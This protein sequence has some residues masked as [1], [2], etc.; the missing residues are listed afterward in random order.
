MGKRSYE[1]QSLELTMW[2][3][4][5]YGG[6]SFELTMLGQMSYGGQ[7]SELTMWGQSKVGNLHFCSF[8]LF[9]FAQN[10]SFQRA[11][12]SSLQKS[13]CERFAHIAL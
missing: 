13:D 1:G 2:D 9:S 3:Q 12:H 5:S 6:Q 4:R 10:R 11:T 7:S 8:A